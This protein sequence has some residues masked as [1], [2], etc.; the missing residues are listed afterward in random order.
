MSV[1]IFPLEVFDFSLSLSSIMLNDHHVGKCIQKPFV[2]FG[3]RDFAYNN[4][5][6]WYA[7]KIGGLR[8]KVISTYL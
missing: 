1:N 4:L 7:K 5:R 3:T 8:K 6:K 2:Q